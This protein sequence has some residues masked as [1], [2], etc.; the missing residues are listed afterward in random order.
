M[1]DTFTG[2]ILSGMVATVALWIFGHL[3]LWIGF[4]KFTYIDVAASIIY[5]QAM[6]GTWLW[7]VMGFIMDLVIGAGLGLV[8]AYTLRATG[9]DYAILKGVVLLITWWFV[10]ITVIQPMWLG[11]NRFPVDALVPLKYLLRD[12]IW[13]AIAAWVFTRYVHTEIKL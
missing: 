4:F 13:G 5:P 1:K 10:V 6:K 11:W 2:G 9:N 7:Y 8:V 12:V 3:M